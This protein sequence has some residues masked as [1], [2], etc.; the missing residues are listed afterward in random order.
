MF[1]RIL[2]F[3]ILLSPFPAAAA[4]F[5]LKDGDRVV[6]I[7]GTLIEREQRYG[8]W[9]AAVTAANPDRTIAFRNLGWSGDTV[10]GEARGGFGTPA[11]GYKNLIDHVKGEKPTVIVVGYGT[12]E[13]FAGMA[14]LPKF[15]D[16]LKRLLDDLAPTKARLVFLSPTKMENL[17]RPL[18][19]PTTENAHLQSYSDAIRE[20][21]D[22]RKAA[23]I[24]LFERDRKGPAHWTDNGL[25]LTAQGYW[26]TASRLLPIDRE[27]PTIRVDFAA[28]TS[29]GEGAII[30]LDAGPGHRFRVRFDRLPPPPPPNGNTYGIGL[31]AQGLPAG[32]W[33]LA[34][35]G[36]DAQ[37]R[38]EKSWG[39]DGTALIHEIPDFA[40]GEKLRQTIVAKNELYFHRWRPQ[41]I[42]YLTGFRK[43]EQGN[44]AVDIPKF[45]PLV[46]A[47]EK[48]IAALRRPVD[49]VYELV[50][51]K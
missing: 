8:Y 15:R 25:H 2:P 34:I 42:T 16:G 20:E 21:A 43:H 5:E 37:A 40:Q 1:P 13:S 9:E 44:N 32:N 33:T 10:W 50:P 11:D 46:A 17:G 28:R 51:A 41:N 27:A 14:G 36:K 18:P 4:E 49:H 6:L 47:K 12:N 38:T 3:L 24:D 26:L 31:Q 29:K 22:R 19:D 23:W 30:K 35:D 45:D 39:D 48:E 7:G